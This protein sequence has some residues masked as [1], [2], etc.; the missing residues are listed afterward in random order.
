MLDVF[1]RLR[2]QGK[3]VLLCLHPSE[4]VHLD[5]LNEVCERYLF[6]H[7]SEQRI[8]ELLFATR[9][10]SWC[11]SRPSRPTWASWR[12]TPHAAR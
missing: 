7:K 12:R 1:R 5:I 8:S 2:G 6:M 10:A 11:A 3:L 9:W 4:P